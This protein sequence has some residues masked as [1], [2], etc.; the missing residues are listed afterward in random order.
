MNSQNKINSK[1]KNLSRNL[2]NPKKLKDEM[3]SLTQSKSSSFL[4]GNLN[5]SIKKISNKP[6]I[7]ESMLQKDQKSPM[8]NQLSNS[9]YVN[10]SEDTTFCY[11]ITSGKMTPIDYNSKIEMNDTHSIKFDVTKDHFSNPLGSTGYNSFPKQQN[12]Q[13]IINNSN[14]AVIYKNDSHKNDIICSDNIEVKISTI[15][16]NKEIDNFFNNE[17]T[18][19]Q[20]KYFSKEGF[21]NIYNKLEVKD[22]NKISNKDGTIPI[23]DESRPVA[24]AN[25]EPIWHRLFVK[26]KKKHEDPTRNNMS[27][28]RGNSLNS[29]MTS[30]SVQIL[31]KSQ[32][33]YEKGMDIIKKKNL[34]H[35]DKKQQTN[36]EY[37]KYTFKPDISLTMNSYGINEKFEKINKEQSTT[38]FRK[39]QIWKNNLNKRNEMIYEY[40]EQE[41]MNVCTFSPEIDQRPAK[42]DV[43]FINKNIQQI[44]SYI[45]N[46]RDFLKRK[47]QDRN[48]AE[49][50]LFI[51]S[52]SQ[53]P[54]SRNRITTP[55]EFNLNKSKSRKNI[56]NKGIFAHNINALAEMR[57]KLN[58]RSFFEESSTGN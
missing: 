13:N 57:S 15:E 52:Q 47:E 55:K 19:I 6:S 10:M 1:L 46:R 25:Q 30:K 44:Y 43:E 9:F 28:Q 29:S 40:Q 34:I 22:E 48:Y 31:N 8:K 4:K 50:K 23:K 17:N 36:N 27:T 49:R 56:S 51:L 14:Q 3:R 18:D 54:Q 12:E 37:K 21:N 45:N 33:L 24:T 38:F 11:A 26:K 2:I 32:E 58:T 39:N 35:Q 7:P 42:N 5:Q 41:K 53:T 20:K 16:R